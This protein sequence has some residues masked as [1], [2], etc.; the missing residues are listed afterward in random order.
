[1]TRSDPAVLADGILAGDARALAR[2]ISLVENDHP[3]ATTLI[4]RL[5][6][7]TGR[8]ELV[9]VTGPPGVGKS[10]LVDALVG[11]VRRAGRTVGVLAVDPTSPFTGGA[12]LGDRIRM[13]RRATDEGVFIRSMATR[14]HLGGLAP[15]TADAALLLDAAGKDT[16]II[17]T[18]GVGQDEVEVATTADV[19]VVVF[20]PGTGDEVQA[21]KAG[22][23]EV[24]DIF[25]VNKADRPGADAM[26]AEL[27]AVLALAEHPPDTWH[28]PVLATEATTGKGVGE[29]LTAI[30]QFA[31]TQAARH[32]ARRRARVE[33][34]L[35]ELL[36]MRFLRYVDEHVWG[37]GA[38]D[39]LVA[40]VVAR[41][42]DPYTAVDQILHRITGKEPS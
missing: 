13:Q 39:A 5:F 20:A 35:R 28:P 26:V 41:E 33:R 23:M 7:H 12:L 25:V 18:V 16:V 27:R 6:A 2:A 3:A 4:R 15:A 32:E 19:C 17:E 22:L 10:T 1:M 21:L 36:Q 11:E 14:G 9:G 8:A 31:R 34:R 30:E 40:R 29:L 37:D 24:G 38:F 42:I